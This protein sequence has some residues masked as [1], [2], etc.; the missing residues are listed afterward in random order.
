MLVIFVTTHGNCII[1][2]NIIPR[3][4]LFAT[5]KHSDDAGALGL[6]AKF[7]S[8]IPLLSHM[9]TTKTLY[10]PYTIYFILINTFGTK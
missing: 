1:D 9:Y 4:I 7:F 10:S 2:V 6:Y 8:D 3:H 5:F